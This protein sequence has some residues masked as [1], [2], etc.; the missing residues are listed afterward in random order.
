[1]RSSLTSPRAA[2]GF[3]HVHRPFRAGLGTLFVAAQFVDIGFAALLIPGV[4]PTTKAIKGLFL[5]RA[6]GYMAPHAPNRPRHHP[7]DRPRTR[8]FSQRI[9]AS[10]GRARADTEQRPEEST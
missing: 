9:C 2:I 8:A 3:R 6:R 7:R 5:S 1:M 4:R 10:S